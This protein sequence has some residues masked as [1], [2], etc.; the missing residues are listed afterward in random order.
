MMW[1]QE[2]GVWGF[3]KAGVIRR[4]GSRWD[5]VSVMEHA[6]MSLLQP[7]IKGTLTRAL[8]ETI[9]HHESKLKLEALHHSQRSSSNI[10]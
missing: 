1:R 9:S 4:V 10:F 2:R 8:Q 5:V 6:N 7:H 3:L